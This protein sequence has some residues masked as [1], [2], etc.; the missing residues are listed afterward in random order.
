[1]T[2]VDGA[3]QGLGL[4]LGGLLADRGDIVP[5][6]DVQASLYLLCGVIGL[7]ALRGQKRLP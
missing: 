1:M 7:V 5:V 2:T 4:L 3:A 6:L